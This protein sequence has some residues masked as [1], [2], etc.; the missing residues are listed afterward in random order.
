MRFTLKEMVDLILNTM[1][2]DSVNSI[3][4]TVESLDIAITHHQVLLL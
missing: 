2:S 4:D 3:T 1:D